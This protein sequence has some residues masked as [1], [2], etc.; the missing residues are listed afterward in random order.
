MK[1]TIEKQK[2][3]EQ[4]IDFFLKEVG[5][6]WPFRGGEHYQLLT[7]L[8]SILEGQS[9]I[10]AGTYQGLSCL[11]LAQN[12]ANKVFTYDISPVNAPFLQNYQNVTII[13]KDI[14][15]ESHDVLKSSKVI[16]LDVDPHDGQQ[17]E[18][19]SRL[20][21]EINYEGFVIADD[22]HLNPNMQF[23]WDSLEERCYDVTDIGHVTGTGIIC[24]GNV[25][26]NII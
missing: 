24:Y 12:K 9:I 16:L 19:F 7:Y 23:W 6:D 10:D 13:T 15:R 22:I 18:V 1:I 8:S 25:E 20:L 21:K 17:E 26:L 3:K 11:C 4:N 5:I 14:N 2:V